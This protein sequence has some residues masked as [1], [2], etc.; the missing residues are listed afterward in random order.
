[1]TLECRDTKLWPISG[2]ITMSLPWRAEWTYPW[3]TFTKNLLKTYDTL[4]SYMVHYSHKIY[5]W[6]VCPRM[7]KIAMN[8]VNLQWELRKEMG[9]C[10]RLRLDCIVDVTPIKLPKVLLLKV[11]LTPKDPTSSTPDDVTW[12]PQNPKWSWQKQHASCSGSQLIFLCQLFCTII[13]KQ[14]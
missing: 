7:L 12:G 5:P 13:L 9:T 11:E 14:L 8:Y 6:S 3:N 1:M 2:C 4:W 10:K